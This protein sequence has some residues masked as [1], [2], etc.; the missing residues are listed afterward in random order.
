MTPEERKMLERADA[1]TAEIYRALF[2][3][4]KGSPKDEEA[5]IVGIRTVVRAYHRSAWAARVIVWL[6][7]V[8][9]MLGAAWAAAATN[10]HDF[11][12]GG[13]K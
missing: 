6:V 1:R 12:S 10:W 3:V 8:A 9:S 7:P 4:P 11:L 5:L 13:G 2:E